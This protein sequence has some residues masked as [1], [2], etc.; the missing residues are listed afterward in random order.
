MSETKSTKIDGPAVVTYV[1]QWMARDAYFPMVEFTVD[2]KVYQW[3]A[4]MD[5]LI[6][7]LSV[8]VKV[9]LTAFARANGKLFRVKW[10]AL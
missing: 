4:D 5:Y 8:G 10:E 1:G 9:K 7:G 2:G 3:R 6:R